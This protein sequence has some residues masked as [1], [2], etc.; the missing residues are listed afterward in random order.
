MQAAPEVTE[1]AVQVVGNTESPTQD[2]AG[3]AKIPPAVKDV[4]C[5]DRDFWMAS[6]A[7]HERDRRDRDHQQRED[8]KKDLENL[9]KMLDQSFSFNIKE[10][11]NL[12]SPFESLNDCLGF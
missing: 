9:Q 8:R 7:E 4:F 3:Q 1:A 6:R 5:P 11:T 12:Y 2:V 10:C